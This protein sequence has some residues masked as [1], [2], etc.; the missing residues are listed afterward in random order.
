M[1]SDLT[2]EELAELRKL[3]AH[4]LPAAA[5]RPHAEAGRAMGLHLEP[6]LSMSTIDELQ[7]L[8]EAATHSDLRFHDWV[9]QADKSWPAIH[10]VL[11]AARALMQC[12]KCIGPC[13]DPTV[14]AEIEQALRAL[15]DKEHRT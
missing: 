15:D 9:E 3:L 14:H 5:D 13:D 8:H 6:E 11:V 2:P 7:R 1:A 4:Q 10:R 12:P